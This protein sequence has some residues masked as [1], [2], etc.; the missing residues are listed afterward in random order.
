MK[1]KRPEE[2]AESAQSIVGHLSYHALG[3]DKFHTI[4]WVKLFAAQNDELPCRVLIAEF[5]DFRNTERTKRAICDFLDTNGYVVCVLIEYG[6]N[7]ASDGSPVID[8]ASAEPGVLT[9]EDGYCLTVNDD[10]QHS[11]TVPA[12]SRFWPSVDMEQV[13]EFIRRGQIDKLKEVVPKH[14][15]VNTGGF[16]HTML[17]IAAVNG[18]AG[19]ME[20][21]LQQ[22]GIEI[23][24]IDYVGATAFLWAAYMLSVD[25]MTLLYRS[26]ASPLAKDEK[27][28]SAFHDV[29]RGSWRYDISKIRACLAFLGDHALLSLVLEGPP[30][31]SHLDRSDNSEAI[32]QEFRLM[33]RRVRDKV[34]E[35]LCDRIVSVLADIVLQYWEDDAFTLLEAL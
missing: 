4:L 27:G 25:S 32:K 33:G 21:L 9:M 12:Q 20:W 15:H 35:Y 2:K 23:D 6:K 28:R 17:Q 31:Y 30:L 34:F 24:A 18:H 13:H 8:S 7:S 11:I 26:G 5:W 10:M 19:V 1:R 14:F 29:V 16:G 22:P 3:K